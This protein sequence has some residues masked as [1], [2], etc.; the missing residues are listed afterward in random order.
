MLSS[1]SAGRDQRVPRSEEGR[2]GG[3]R[4]EPRA[5][6][7]ERNTKGMDGPLPSWPSDW[8]LP[9]EHPFP[10]FT[11][12][13]PRLAPPCFPTRLS[14]GP[15][16]NHHFLSRPNARPEA[17]GLESEAAP[18]EDHLARQEHLLAPCSP[19]L[20]LQ[21]EKLKAANRQDFQ[22]SLRTA[23]GSQVPACGWSVWKAVSGLRLA[24]APLAPLQ[25]SDSDIWG[26][27]VLHWADSARPWMESTDTTKAEP[28]FPQ[29][30]WP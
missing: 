14:S 21:L 2:G 29:P 12:C 25:Y 22:G 5:G 19:G 9:R 26:G 13:S 28:Q 6:I 24:G 15:P 23:L 17:G 8:G 18:R 4:C 11:V 3:R 10:A 16:S 7:S 30:K 20:W 27:E 1:Q